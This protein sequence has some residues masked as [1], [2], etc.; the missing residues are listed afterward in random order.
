MQGLPL[1]L[2][3]KSIGKKDSVEVID[4]ML[5]DTREKSAG[6]EGLS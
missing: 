3:G 1:E 5:K 2:I 6:L 4:L